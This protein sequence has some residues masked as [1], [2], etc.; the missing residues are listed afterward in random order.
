M[1]CTNC[2]GEL[3]DLEIKGYRMMVDVGKVTGPTITTKSCIACGL[4]HFF[5]PRYA[6]SD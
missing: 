2:D 5:D 1:S 6:T 3:A 4:V